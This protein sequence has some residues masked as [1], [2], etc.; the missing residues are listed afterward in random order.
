M[1][2]GVSTA[3]APVTVMEVLTGSSFS[4]VFS[5]AGFSGGFSSCAARGKHQITRAQQAS[6]APS[7]LREPVRRRAEHNVV[8]GLIYRRF[9][10]LPGLALHQSQILQNS[11]NIA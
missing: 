5:D 4:G 2:A 3:I 6:A 1:F 8:T 7:R 9:D 11:I 10:S